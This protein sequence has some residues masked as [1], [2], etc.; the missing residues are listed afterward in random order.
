MVTGAGR[1]IGA[2]I[3]HA[4]AEAGASVV[5]ASRTV[6][7]IE[8]VAAAIRTAGGSAIAA[9]TDVTDTFALG[10]LATA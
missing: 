10:S 4:L 1:G 5:L 9:P 3:A 2:G 7:E 8:Q 6:D